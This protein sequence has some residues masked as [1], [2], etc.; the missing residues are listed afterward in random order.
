[1]S[2]RMEPLKMQ[3]GQAVNP[4]TTTPTIQEWIATHKVARL[5]PYFGRLGAH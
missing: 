5:S 3:A 1:M 4:S 2:L